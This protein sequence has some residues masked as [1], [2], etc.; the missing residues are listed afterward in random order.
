MTRDVSVMICTWNNSR[1]LAAALTALS[2]CVIPEQ[3]SWELVIVDNNCT[4][5]TESVVGRF[6][7]VLP[8][9]YLRES[10][11]GLSHARNAGL[12]VACGRLII[13]TDDDVRPDPRWIAAYWTAYQATP[14]GCYFG[15]PVESEFEGGKPDE[16]LV[17]IA[18]PSTKGLHWGPHARRLVESEGFAGA[19]WA[20]PAQA[21]AGGHGFDTSLG[22]V[23]SSSQ[24]LGEETDLMMRLRRDGMFPWY[25]PDAR[26]SH[27]VPASKCTL[28][29]IAARYEAFGRY[30]ARAALTGRPHPRT[31]WGW[32]RWLFRE[33]TKLWLKWLWARARGQ[34]AYGEYAKWRQTLGML[35]ATRE[36]LRS[37]GEEI[38]R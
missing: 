38:P 21:L 2:E 10:R 37:G 3:F 13:F 7:N 23:S 9:V 20:C 31:V 5:D 26:L 8:I 30:S 18:F 16:D 1:R 6:V 19:N 34:K 15:G 14:P 32:P 28:E 12:S 25:L 4:D 24:M 36:L 33:T 27:F 22:L 17:R 11:Q 35:R 29:H